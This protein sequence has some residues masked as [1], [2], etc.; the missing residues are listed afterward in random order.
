MVQRRHDGWL[1]IRLAA[2]NVA[3]R[4]LRAILLGVA[5]M[6]GVGIGFASFVAGW[7]LR[8][9]MAVSFARMGADLLEVRLDCFDNLVRR[10]VQALGV[11]AV[12]PVPCQALPREF[13]DDAFYGS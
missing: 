9:G 10:S 2:Q 11:D 3:R 7:A 5:V 12:T 4:Q 1:L 8:E 6:L 13:E